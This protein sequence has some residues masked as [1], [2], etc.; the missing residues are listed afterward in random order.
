MTDSS[1]TGPDDSYALLAKLL[2]QHSEQERADIRRALFRAEA[3][4]R[5]Q[6]GE[7][8]QVTPLPRG[9]SGAAS[10][11]VVVRRQGVKPS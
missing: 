3:V 1:G 10:I 11:K 2:D 5:Q 4:P 7:P 9:K 6:C 8:G